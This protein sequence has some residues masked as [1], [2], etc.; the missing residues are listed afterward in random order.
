MASS[1]TICTELTI[2]QRYFVKTLYS[3]F[4]AI[5]HETLKLRIEV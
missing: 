4:T 5:D 2:T 3:E 1:V